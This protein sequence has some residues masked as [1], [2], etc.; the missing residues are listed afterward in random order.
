MQGRGEEAWD[1]DLCESR[2]EGRSGDGAQHS[3]E[4][5]ACCALWKRSPCH[6]FQSSRNCVSLTPHRNGK[7]PPGPCWSPTTYHLKGS[8]L[9]SKEGLSMSI[10][11]IGRDRTVAWQDPVLNFL[12][13]IN[14]EWVYCIRSKL[15]LNTDSIFLFLLCV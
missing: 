7:D 1:G 14:L 12:T 4:T 2:L 15:C 8:L 6:S 5:K 9:S 10:V 3:Q 13:F 11:Q